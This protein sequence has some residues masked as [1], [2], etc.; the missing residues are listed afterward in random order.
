VITIFAVS[1]KTLA[2]F[3]PIMLPA[4]RTGL[5]GMLLAKAGLLIAVFKRFT[6]VLEVLPKILE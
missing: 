6:I 3:C 1:Y 2:A 4:L 5:G